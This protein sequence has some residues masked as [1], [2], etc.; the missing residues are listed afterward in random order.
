MPVGVSEA[1]QEYAFTL[2]IRLKQKEHAFKV[3]IISICSVKRNITK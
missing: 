1:C 3:F 2:A